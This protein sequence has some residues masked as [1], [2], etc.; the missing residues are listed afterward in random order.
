M[1]ERCGKF[2]GV[3]QQVGLAVHLARSLDQQ[4]GERRVQRVARNQFL[5]GR[6]HL[7]RRCGQVLAE[8]EGA[9]RNM[10][11]RQIRKAAGI[12]FGLGKVVELHVRRS[13]QLVHHRRLRG[14]ASQEGCVDLAGHQCLG[15]FVA[16]EGQQLCGAV[17]LDPVCLEQCER[18]LARTA[19]FSPNG[20]PLAFE[21]GQP[22][23]GRTVI[24]QR[25]W[26]ICHA[27]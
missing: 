22:R 15:G 12:R 11:L 13:S 6:H 4:I 25:Q 8:V 10:D 17:R 1:G 9:H 16:G 18:Q 20:E 26:H 23:D 7:D 19:A 2:A 27:A 5:G 24:E 14:I 3:L 21:F